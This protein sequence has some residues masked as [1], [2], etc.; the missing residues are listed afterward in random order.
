MYKIIVPDLI[1]FETNLNH[2]NG[3]NL[4][5]NFNFYSESE[6]KNQF[7]YKIIIN[8]NIQ[9]P[10]KY[11]FRNG[12]YL[13]LENNWFYDRKIFWRFHLK[14][15]YNQENKEFSCN[16][17][18][19]IVPFELGGILPA[20]KLIADIINLDLFLK[21]NHI[22]RGCAV[23]NKKE[24][25]C[26]IAPGYNGK[27]TFI[28][29]ILENGGKYISEDMLIMNFEKNKVYPTSPHKNNYG[30]KINQYLIKKI[31][32]SNLV[33][34]S[35]NI[36]KIVL[37]QN[38]TNNGI[39]TNDKKLIDYLFMNSLLFLDNNLIKSV[40]F[41]NKMTD[42]ILSKIS[43]ICSKKINYKFINISNFNYHDILK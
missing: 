32:K 33:I 12:Y 35:F 15:K 25:I 20:G 11:D 37:F 43:D 22:F 2:L 38:T 36:D 34:E 6:E 41:Q 42:L 17:L 7:H 16:R 27:T 9:I 8:N 1:S 26:I 21:D 31:N 39:L 4:S 13:K 14:F 24:N 29:N 3:F 28:K 18:F 23:N 5:G 10:G 30:R 19:S 40:I